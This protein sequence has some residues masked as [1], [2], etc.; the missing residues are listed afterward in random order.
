MVEFLL[1]NGADVN[2]RD[3]FQGYTPLDGAKSEEMKKLLIKYGGKR[4]G[5]PVF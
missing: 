3:D 5:I 4:S 2:G 1:K